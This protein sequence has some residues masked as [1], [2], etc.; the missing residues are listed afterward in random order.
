MITISRRQ[1][2]ELIAGR[3]GGWNQGWTCGRFRGNFR[4]KGGQILLRSHLHICIFEYLI[5]YFSYH[6]LY[7]NYLQKYFTHFYERFVYEVYASDNDGGD[8]DD[9]GDD[10]DDVDASVL[11]RLKRVTCLKHRHLADNLQSIVLLVEVFVIKNQKIKI[12]AVLKN[13]NPNHLQVNFQPVRRGSLLSCFSNLW[14]FTKLIEQIKLNEKST[15]SQTGNCTQQLQISVF[16]NI[17][18]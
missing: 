6:Y 7:Y 16:V 14:L 5:I 8:N 9:C 2:D 12:N 18:K 4:W 17:Y 11:K 1:T 3:W 10:D 13:L 15:K